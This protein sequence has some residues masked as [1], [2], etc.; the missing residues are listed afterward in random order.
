MLDYRKIHDSLIPDAEEKERLATIVSK[1]IREVDAEIKSRKLDASAELVG[2]LSKG[3]NLKNGD[4]D[5]FIVFPRT[6]SREEI[7]KHGLSIGHKV[8]PKALERY[9]EHP[10]VYG[11]LDDTKVDIVPC[12]RMKPNEKIKS[13][14]D[15]SPLHT[16]WVRE[17][18]DDKLR[19]E[20]I[21]LKGFMKG[22]GVY[23]SE[24]AKGG[25][26]GYVCEILVIKLRTFLKVL[27]LF[28]S[29]EKRL[30]F[31]DS[32]E[33][34]KDDSLVLSDPVDPGR[35]AAAAVSRHNLAKMRILS[36]EYLHESSEEYFHGLPRREPSHFDRGTVFRIISI[37]R[38]DMIDDII[39]PQIAKFRKIIIQ[40]CEEGGFNPIDSEVLASDKIH[41]LIELE[42]AIRPTFRVHEGPPGDSGETLKFL[43]KWSSD[44]TIRGPYMR[45]ERPAVEIPQE[46]EFDKFILPAL[47]QKDIGATLNTLKGSIRVGG[48]NNSRAHKEI[49]RKYLS[50]NLTD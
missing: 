30:S 40:E 36:R 28:A 9:A 27:E 22:I 44:N 6:L 35:N 45:G 14:V 8:L 49:M 7:V 16:K 42:R 5:V 34:G 39:F 32:I 46:P 20:I 15:R 18:T 41:L 33:N 19:F 23:G 21:L 12:F 17:N 3:T 37:D 10:Y 4:I 24:V 43:D 1:I 29:S 31:D 13:A 26:S 47:L 38:P 11:F 2:S 50:R 25:F 48:I